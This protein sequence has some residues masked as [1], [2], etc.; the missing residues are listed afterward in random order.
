LEA[1]HSPNRCK[2]SRPIEHRESVGSGDGLRVQYSVGRVHHVDRI[3]PMLDERSHNQPQLGASVVS[4]R[5][6]ILFQAWNAVILSVARLRVDFDLNARKNGHPKEAPNDCR[7]VRAGRRVRDMVPFVVSRDRPPSSVPSKRK[8]TA[9]LNDLA[10]LLRCNR[11]SL[12]RREGYCYD[13]LR[14]IHKTHGSFLTYWRADDLEG[15]R[16]CRA[17][18][19]GS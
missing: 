19:V 4:R 6:L 12:F 3:F 8:A 10:A 18:H 14:F 5:S 11:R 1:E 16:I 7:N 17:R 9:D 13:R 2:W 15:R